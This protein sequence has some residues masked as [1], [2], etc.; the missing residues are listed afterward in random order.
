MNSENYIKEREQG[1][2][3]QSHNLQPQPHEMRYEV[4]LSCKTFK[5]KQNNF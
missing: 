4:I 2:N 1:E 5:E 3:L